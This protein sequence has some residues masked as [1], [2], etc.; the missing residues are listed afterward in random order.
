MGELETDTAD[1]LTLD[2]L[3]SRIRS[4]SQTVLVILVMHPNGS[5]WSTIADFYEALLRF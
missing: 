2:T 3:A 1:M 5:L 4:D